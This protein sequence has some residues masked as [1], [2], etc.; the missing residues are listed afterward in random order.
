MTAPREA[1]VS[2]P[3]AQIA[4]SSFNQLARSVAMPAA[5]QTLEAVVRDLLRPL[6]KDWLDQNLPS[7]VEAQVQAE[8]ARISR[9]QGM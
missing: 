3:A 5:G 6:L 1:L 2:A 8:V 4:A 9:S 7:I